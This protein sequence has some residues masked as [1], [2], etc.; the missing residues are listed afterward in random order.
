MRAR[1]GYC[2]HGELIVVDCACC[3]AERPLLLRIRRLRMAL[4]NIQRHSRYVGHKDGM[5]CECG[6]CWAD[7]ALAA[8]AKRRK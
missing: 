6:G 8:D 4:R 3:N 2:A 7:R 1:K 5:R